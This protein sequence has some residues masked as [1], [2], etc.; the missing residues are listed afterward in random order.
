[1][2]HELCE[3]VNYL[4]AEWPYHVDLFGVQHRILEVD[5]QEMV[6]VLKASGSEYTTLLPTMINA[7]ELIGLRITDQLEEYGGVQ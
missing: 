3:Q 2:I 5:E 4:L 7:V 6:L 1:M